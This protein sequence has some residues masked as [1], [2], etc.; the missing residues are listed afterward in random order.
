MLGIVTFSTDFKMRNYPKIN[1][2]KHL[3]GNFSAAMHEK[4]Q[5]TK[6]KYSNKEETL[7]KT[8]LLRCTNTHT[9]RKTHTH[10]VLYFCSKP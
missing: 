6:L 2:N 3:L 5:Q 9:E 4:I 8:K 7:E 10:T 1:K